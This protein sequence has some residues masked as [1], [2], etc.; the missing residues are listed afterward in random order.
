MKQAPL[1]P[2]SRIARIEIGA[3][4]IRIPCRSEREASRRGTVRAFLP[5]SSR[6][7]PKEKRIRTS[8]LKKKIQ[9]LS[10]SRHKASMSRGIAFQ[11]LLQNLEIR[12]APPCPPADVRHP[13]VRTCR[14]LC[15][16]FFKNE[17]ARAS[18]G[19]IAKKSKKNIK[20]IDFCKIIFFYDVK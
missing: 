1:R 5:S 6:L 11:E 9:F 3:D 19:E 20:S 17:A 18:S 15:R 4:G 16:I 13:D 2:R 7:K 8:C 14:A 10:L 12:N